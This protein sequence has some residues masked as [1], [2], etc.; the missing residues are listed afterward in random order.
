MT[1]NVPQASRLLV[2]GAQCAGRQAGG[3][4]AVRSTLKLDLSIARGLDY[5]TGT[6]YETFLTELPGSGS[7]MSGGRYDNL[8]E[9][10]LG[11]PMPAV[12]ISVGIDRLLSYLVELGKVNKSAATS[13]VCVVA[14]EASCL[15]RAL[16]VL[17]AF[18]AAGVAAEM[19]IENEQKPKVDRQLSLAGKRGIPFAA[20]IGGNELAQGTVMLKDLAARRQEEMTFEQAVA[21]LR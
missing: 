6:V 17:G 8:I 1:A 2:D 19:V 4:P 12:G 16:E 10:Y 15:N 20:I 3:T 7:V 5:Y 18:R 9:R 14:M 13:R 11:K 21:K